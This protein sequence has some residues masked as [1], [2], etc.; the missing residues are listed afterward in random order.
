MNAARRDKLRANAQRPELQPAL[1]QLRKRAD[2]GLGI[3]FPIVAGEQAGWGH[4]YY[5]EDGTGLRFDWNDRSRHTCPACGKVYTGEPYDSAW[6]GAAHGSTC[7]NL[8]SMG[9][10]YAI[11]GDNRYAERVVKDLLAYAEHYEGYTIHGDIPYNGPGKLFAQTLDEAQWI[12]NLAAA[13]AYVEER[14]D[15]K[16]KRLIA[17]GLLRPCA[18][19]LIGH[20]ERQLHNHAIIITSAIGMLGY[21]LEDETI[22]RAGLDGPYGL[23]DQIDRGV[24]GDGFWYEGAFGYHF[25]ALHPILKYC[26]IVEGSPWDLRHHATLKRMFDFPLRYLLTDG[27]FPSVNDGSRH[28]MIHSFA[29]AYE[30]A[31]EWY[32]EDLYRQY[33]RCAY[34]INDEH[35]R[36]FPHGAIVPVSRISLEALLFGGDLR[37]DAADSSMEE[38]GLARIVR[39]PSAS[40]SGGLTK[41]AN[42]RGWN[43][44][45]KHGT[46]GGEH[47]H[48]DR[49]GLSFTAGGTPLVADIGTT[50]YGIP[51]HYGW[52]KH[53]YSHNTVNID[54]KDQPPTDG[55]LKQ[56]REE[57]WGAWLESAVD[58]NGGAYYLQDKIILPPE[59]CPWD[60]E[61]YEQASIR[62]INAL[63]GDC[64]IDIV[65]VVVPNAC[66][67]Q[68]NYHVSGTLAQGD[69][70]SHTDKPFGAL[71]ATWFGN[72]RTKR[73]QPGETL[74]WA[75]KDGLLL[76]GGWCSRDAALYTAETP[77]NPPSGCRQ[78]LIQQARTDGE[79]VFVNVFALVEAGGNNDREPLSMRVTDR[80]DGPNGRAAFTLDVRLP[81][82]MAHFKFGWSE[83]EAHFVAI[84]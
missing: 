17:D 16:Q 65:K 18:A 24:L 34:G 36:A 51:A 78:S 43:V 69:E 1:E 32:G 48:M 63:T 84:G 19:F 11:S 20:K 25:Y 28:A 83:D 72:K 31:L 6:L 81:G 68:L 49:L 71:E 58:W 10:M 40:V 12:M 80:T 3:E 23:L 77:D 76:Q 60:D 50:A 29:W 26:Q 64:L 67:V 55:T 14:L 79:V 5:C 38:S 13:Y 22:H 27:S 62:R 59:M 52:F 75:V 30:V 57:P 56:L 41:L 9:H 66:N 82:R 39:S 53:T 74:E 46:F 7:G 47:D 37:A 61:A 8:M 44:I 33:L 15:P 54:G 4:Y 70:W 42:D 35:R 45:V 73:M 21:L 2:T